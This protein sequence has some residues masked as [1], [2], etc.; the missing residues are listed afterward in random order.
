MSMPLNLGLSFFTGPPISAQCYWGAG[1]G[2]ARSEQPFL[3]CSQ[4]TRYGVL[5]EGVDNSNF[6]IPC[7]LLCK[8][9]CQD[10]FQPECCPQCPSPSSGLELGPQGR[11][12]SH[13]KSFC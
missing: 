8:H 12:S 2:G 13:L 6:P 7:E 3:P 4:E 11:G 9:H 10:P 1:R 5:G